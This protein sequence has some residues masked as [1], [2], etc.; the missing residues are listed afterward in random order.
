MVELTNVQKKVVEFI[1]AHIESTGMPP[2]LR[3]I[4][5]NFNWKAVGSAQDVI[6]A[7]R[8]KGVLLSPA[9]GKARQ[10]VPVPEIISGLFDPDT[11][12][13][14]I[15]TYPFSK[16][17]RYSITSTREEQLLPGFDEP[18]RVPLLGYVQAGSPHEAIES[19]SS[20]TTFPAL[21]R[22]V[23]RGGI[24]FALSVEGYS[25]LNAGF[26]PGDAIL[27]E[28]S[29]EAFDRDIIVA[30][31]SSQDVTVKRF[32][33]KGSSTY[34][35]ALGFFSKNNFNK[36]SPPAFLVPENPDFEPIPFGLNEDEKIVGI[37]RS[38]YRRSVG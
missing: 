11:E 24:L 12:I 14:A 23:L 8:K 13:N 19:N 37:V 20:F 16:K 17:K 6:T 27:V 38:L 9:S 31:L 32:A 18:L 25:M 2:T 5:A 35:S 21:S 4:S 1:L 10:I 29:L 33:K 7:L 30:R 34:R 3:E 36:L 15:G 28:T 22:G 26:L